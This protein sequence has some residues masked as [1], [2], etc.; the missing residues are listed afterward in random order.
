VRL[1]GQVE[2]QE[3]GEHVLLR[4]FVRDESH[5]PLADASVQA[6]LEGPGGAKRQVA[7]RPVGRGEYAELFVPDDPGAWR[8]RVGAFSE[9]RK[10]GEDQGTFR[11]GRLWDENQDTAPDFAALRRLAEA[12]GGEFLPLEEFSFARL[13]EKVRASA[14][15]SERRQALWNAP[16]ALALLA[17]CLLGDWLLRRRRG[18]P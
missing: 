15:T 18:E 17:G 16:W 3:L 7:L 4:A 2:P 12:T 1:A 6:T 14:W 11:A 13:E 10:I 8:V 5:R 9:R